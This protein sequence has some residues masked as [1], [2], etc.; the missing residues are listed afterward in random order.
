MHWPIW[1]I[2]RNGHKFWIDY[3]WVCIYI[4]HYV[5]VSLNSLCCILLHIL[6]LL[7]F[8]RFRLERYFP[9]KQNNFSGNI[10]WHIPCYAMDELNHCYK[11]SDNVP[12]IVRVDVFI[13]KT[14]IL[15]SLPGLEWWVPRSTF[16]GFFKIQM[17]DHR[18]SWS[19]TTRESVIIH[20]AFKN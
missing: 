11:F 10:Y 20:D 3:I 4:F 9:N 15:I 18:N 1:M 16:T 5:C 19:Y 12:A 17:R 13:C 7:N 14:I 6:H 2:S 8:H